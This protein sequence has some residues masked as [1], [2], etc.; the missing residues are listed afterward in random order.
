MRQIPDRKVIVEKLK[1]FMAD[2]DGGGNYKY[3]RFDHLYDRLMN[4][5]SD[6]I[7]V[8]SEDCRVEQ[9]R[10]EWTTYSNINIWF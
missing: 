10:L 4:L 6:R 1:V 9:R 5:I 8:S 2:R 3:K 7:I